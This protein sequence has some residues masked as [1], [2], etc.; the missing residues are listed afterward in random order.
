[1]PRNY[2]IQSRFLNKELN[3]FSIE[4]ASVILLH[5]ITAARNASSGYT[6]TDVY[7]DFFFEH[8][9]EISINFCLC[10][11]CVM[12]LWVLIRRSWIRAY[13]KILQNEGLELLNVEALGLR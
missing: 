12:S 4:N 11:T 7:A 3:I 6:C 13:G 9:Y 10:Y 5:G 2:K 1:M 8:L